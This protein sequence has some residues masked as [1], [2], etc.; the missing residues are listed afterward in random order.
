MPTAL[1]FTALDLDLGLERI[2]DFD[3]DF[4]EVLLGI[5]FTQLGEGAFGQKFA[6]VNDAD[7]VTE[8]FDFAHDV[9]GE[10]DGFTAV[11]AFTDE[12]GDSA[13]GH[14]VK[15]KGGFVENHY[16]RVVDQGAG[17]GSLLLHAGGKL[18]AAAVAEGVHVQAIEDD[19]EALLEGGFVETVEAAKIFDELLG[20]EAGVERGGGGKKADVGANFFGMLDNVVA[21]D[22]GGAVGGLQ[23]GGEHAQGGGLAGAV[24]AE[25]AVD[26][27]GLAGEAD[28]IDGADF[29]ALLVLEALGQATSF[30]HRKIPQWEFVGQG[31]E[32]SQCTTRGTGKCYGT[33]KGD[34]GMGNR[35]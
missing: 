21:A 10:D 14:D 30:N 16:W 13:S 24:G 27:A 9:G 22:E 18:V 33:E 23:D 1:R 12:G 7:D 2:D 6:V 29:T 8:L 4:L 17:D 34:R 35:E 28:V 26:L 32:R 11:A 25:Q 3:E 15:A 31:T 5:F 19:V 20:G